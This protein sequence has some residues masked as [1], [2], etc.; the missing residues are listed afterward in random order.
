MQ[1]IA[2]F[3]GTFDPIH[4]GHIGTALYFQKALSLDKII[5]I[6]TNLPPHK[7]IKSN[8]P[9]EIRME[10]CSIAVRDYPF[11]EVSNLEINRNGC[12]YTVDTLEALKDIYQTAEFYLIVG[13]DMFLTITDWKKS[14]RIFELATICAVP[15]N[16]NNYSV[17][18]QHASE[19]QKQGV[20]SVVADVPLVRV[21]ST[22]IREKVKNDENISAFVP[23]TIQEY[24]IK[25]NLYKGVNP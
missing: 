8:T 16:G 1:K 24:I 6:P 11:F 20:K 22:M 7:E 23:Q 4:N 21:S 10:M 9:A 5:F 12:S 3:G 13:A 14:D 25:N 19:L 15:R 18:D 17:L 2:M